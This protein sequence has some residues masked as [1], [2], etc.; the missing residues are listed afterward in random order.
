MKKPDLLNFLKRKYIHTYIIVVLL[1]RKILSDAQSG[2]NYL[3]NEPDGYFK[4]FVRKSVSNLYSESLTNGI[5]IFNNNV[6][7]GGKY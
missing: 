5:Q 6:Q 2:K 3:E 1:K 7:N 4:I